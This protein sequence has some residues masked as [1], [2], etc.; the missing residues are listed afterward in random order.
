M[1]LFCDAVPPWYFEYLIHNV[2]A[3][4]VVVNDLR[5]ET[6]DSRFESGC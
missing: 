4:S 3:R 5:L 2:I 6:K 1:I